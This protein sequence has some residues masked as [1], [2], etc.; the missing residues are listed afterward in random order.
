MFLRVRRAVLLCLGF[1]CLSGNRNLTLISGSLT[2]KITVIHWCEI[3]TLQS[4]AWWLWAWQWSLNLMFSEA[5]VDGFLLQS[6]FNL[7]VS[8]WSR[9]LYNFYLSFS[10]IFW[11]G[12]IST[13]AVRGCSETGKSGIREILSNRVP[14]SSCPSKP[15]SLAVF[16]PSYVPFTL[17]WLWG[18]GDNCWC[19]ARETLHCKFP[20]CVRA[21]FLVQN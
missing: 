3:P 19:Y 2:A 1:A 21:E 17:S 5:Q 6:S 11:I 7:L 4:C 13:I 12:N 10:C 15:P 9:C 18:W 8:I 16:Q 14:H 20:A